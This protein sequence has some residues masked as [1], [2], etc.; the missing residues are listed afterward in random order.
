[1][2][3]IDLE[4]MNKNKNKAEINDDDDLYLEFRPRQHLF[5]NNLNYDIALKYEIHRAEGLDNPNSYPLVN[6]RIYSAESWIEPDEE[7]IQTN[8]VWGLPNPVWDE[9]C[10]VKLNRF[11]DVK[12]LHVEVLRHGSWSEPGTSDGIVCVGRV[13]IPLP[14]ELYASKGGSVH[15]ADQV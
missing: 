2:D 4:K 13:R 11:W 10:C 5:T 9:E 14:E 7:K 12:F 1:M 15:E 6:N 3:K 8:R